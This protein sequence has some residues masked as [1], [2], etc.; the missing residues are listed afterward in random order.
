MGECP[1]LNRDHDDIDQ[2]FALACNLEY[3]RKYLTVV[4][5]NGAFVTARP[6]SLN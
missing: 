4:R 2:S 1:G 3:V 5:G 6:V